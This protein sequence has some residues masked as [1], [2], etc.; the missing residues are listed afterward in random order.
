MNKRKS[1]EIALSFLLIILA[2]TAIL[3]TSTFQNGFNTVMLSIA[4]LLII[5]A[6]IGF[7]FCISESPTQKKNHAK[8]RKLVLIEP[9]NLDKLNVIKVHTEENLKSIA[10]KRNRE[11]F[12]YPY[13]ENLVFLYVISDGFTY[14]Y[15]DAK[16]ESESSD[17]GLVV[18]I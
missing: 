8:I 10:K 9:I 16:S 1:H 14:L 15:I 11:I 17:E 13:S 6:I 3:V 4:I 7:A 5:A 12:F 2:L 18:N